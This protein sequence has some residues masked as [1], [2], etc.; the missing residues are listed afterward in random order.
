MGRASFKSR[1]SDMDI[2][3]AIDKRRT[4]R[5]FSAPLSEQQ[6]GSILLAGVKAPSGSNVQPWEFIIVD[7]PKLIEQ[8]AEHKYQQTLKMALDNIFLNDPSTIEKVFNRTEAIPVSQRGALRQKDAYQRCTVL[9]VCHQ[10]GHGIGR[11]PWMNV[12][13]SA[14][15]WACIENIMLAATGDGVGV[16]ISIFREEH[17]I[18]V[19]KLLGVTDDFEL[20]TILLLGIPSEPARAREMGSPRPDFSWLH[21]NSLGDRSARVS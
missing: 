1:G 4:I 15:T 14:S 7:D 11:K 5:H 13:N 21:R 16:Q 20:A 2:Y 10:K 9:A 8:I 3:E 19:E 12:E 18:A 17:K 6:L